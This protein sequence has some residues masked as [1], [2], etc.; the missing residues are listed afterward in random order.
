MRLHVQSIL[1]AAL[2]IGAAALPAQSPGPAYPDPAR[3]EEEIRAFE[4]ADRENPPPENAILCIGSSSMKGWHSAIEEDLAPLTVV[5]RGFGG[6]NMND[7]LHFADRIVI[8]YQPRAILLYEGDNDT[9]AG[10]PHER[11]LDT[12]HQFVAKVRAELPECRIYVLSIKPSI[13]RWN[14]WPQVQQ[15]NQRFREACQNDPLL[16]YVDIAQSMLD[17][18]GEPRPSFFVD[19]DL[20]MTRLGYEAWRADVR[21]VLLYGELQYEPTGSQ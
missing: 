6:S 7:V 1:L 21:P 18:D 19:D 3:F 4:A 17:Q 13:A 14:I 11:I 12:F 5:P 15:M 10:I 16:T 2:L 9:A 20:H 8:P